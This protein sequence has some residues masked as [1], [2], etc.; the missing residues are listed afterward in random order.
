MDITVKV[1]KKENCSVELSVTVAESELE[2]RKESLLIELRDQVNI[3]GFRKGHVPKAILE[4][5]FGPH[6]T[7]E[8]LEDVIKAALH[9][10]FVREKLIPI[11]TPKVSDIRMDNG[12]VVFKAAVEVQPDIELKDEQI[13]GIHL[14]KP[15]NIQ[16]TDDDV[17][18]AIDS[19]RKALSTF[20]PELEVR[21]VR[22]GDF[23]VIDFEGFLKDPERPIDGWKGEGT[24]IEVG[25]GRFLPGFDESVVGMN[26]SDKK[27]IDV[28]FPKD[29]YDEELQDK[30]A[31][32]HVTLKAIKK[33]QMPE[34]TDAWAKEHGYTDMADMK[35]KIRTEM[36]HGAESM[37]KDEMRKAL[38]AALDEKISV[39]VPPSMVE[40]RAEEM[41]KN[42][43]RQY[44]GGRKELAD[45]LKKEGKTEADLEADIRLRAR[46]QIKT[47][48]IIATVAR[49]KD[50]QV[51][52]E[53][54]KSRIAQIAAERQ[55]SPDD[56]YAELEKDDRLGDIEYSLLTEKVVQ[57]LLEHA[58]TR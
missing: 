15:A 20:T 3:P 22:K 38:Y 50:I 58:D 13:L 51:T 24:L 32:F 18:S 54:L 56:L 27:R 42:L 7:A 35:A 9:E 5:R 57:F 37:G 52:P 39:D 47:S 19:E 11:E 4:K 49:T 21:P 53:D 23:V 17:A 41:M 33:Q 2:T 1:E 46:Q 43:E 36:E 25:A 31:F 55:I 6:A 48:L 8:A 12:Q 28:V 45:R 34:A 44:K 16:V 26:P 10:A 14:P 40:R 29:F 30:P